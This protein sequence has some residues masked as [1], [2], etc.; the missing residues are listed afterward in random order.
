MAKQPSATSTWTSATQNEVSLVEFVFALGRSWKTASLFV[1]TALAIGAVWALLQPKSFEYQGLL[2]MG[3]VSPVHRVLAV[4]EHTKAEPKVER[5]TPEY[6][7]PQITHG[8][9]LAVVN[10]QFLRRNFDVNGV[11]AKLVSAY[12]S[13]DDEEL[14]K[15]TVEARTAEAAKAHLENIA[16]W[17]QAHFRDDLSKWVTAHEARLRDLTAEIQATPAPSK[18][19]SEDARRFYS[20]LGAELGELKSSLAFAG[21]DAFTFAAIS[22]PAP[23]S[24]KHRLGI[25]MTLG[26]FVG[27]VFAFFWV[28]FTV[29]SERA[30]LIRKQAFV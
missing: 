20:D 24:L 9:V 6:G 1:A 18:S 13:Y 11:P 4:T 27:L 23:A 30:S 2:K 25:D 26:L 21:K 16:A 19:T 29:L 8:E 17:V 5:K 7:G 15:L 22:E 10:L 3:P 28:F 14:L 12:Y